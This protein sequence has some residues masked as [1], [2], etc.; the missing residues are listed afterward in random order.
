MQQLPSPSKLDLV[1]YKFPLPLFHSTRLI[2]TP[3]YSVLFTERKPKNEAV[4][5]A[6]SLGNSLHQ[7][8]TPP[9]LAPNRAK[10][11]TAKQ[12]LAS[13]TY[14]GE[15]KA[16]ARKSMMKACVLLDECT[17]TKVIFNPILDTYVNFRLA[18]LTLTFPAPLT[19]Q[20]QKNAYR[21]QLSPF[22]EWLKKWHNLKNFVWKAERTKKGTLH[23]HLMIDTFVLN[24]ELSNRWNQ[25]TALSEYTESTTRT[26]NT[27]GNPSIEITACSNSESASKYINK[28]MLKAAVKKG[29]LAR[30][31]VPQEVPIIGKVWGANDKLSQAKRPRFIP[32]FA[33]IEYL[34]NLFNTSPNEITT[35]AYHAIIKV[36]SVKIFLLLDWADRYIQR[37]FISSIAIDST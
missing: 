1:N 37:A 30:P 15:F 26:R 10:Q 36:P 2:V 14:T 29:E 34:T 35:S 28:Y 23:Y 32:S 33:C 12:N 20:A 27:K 21:Q 13:G 8:Q 25:L 5:F 11:I 7:R 9:D 17:S 18:F 22:I 6:N 16:H 24:T 4:A 31:D 3:T 19:L